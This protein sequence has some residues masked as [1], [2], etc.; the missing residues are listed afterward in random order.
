MKTLISTFIAI[1]LTSHCLA[2]TYVPIQVDMKGT[3]ES[4]SGKSAEEKHHRWLE[5]KVAGSGIKEGA[6]LRLEWI[7]FA[8]DL[9]GGGIIKQGEGVETVDLQPGKSGSV[10]TKEVVFDYTRQ[11]A[12]RIRGGRRPVYKNVK[13]TG[14][15]Y[16]GWLV[17]AFI[18]KE[19]VG[20]AAS[21]RDVAKL[22]EESVSSHPQ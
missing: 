13:A 8:D 21:T 3:H 12:E 18:G 1:L 11:H 6:Q 10:K 14:H 15:R 7:F 20:E 2:G 17:R 22:G 5:V 16:H 9:T 19:K 4:H